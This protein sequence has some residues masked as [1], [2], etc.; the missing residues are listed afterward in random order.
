MEGKYFLKVH[1]AQGRNLVAVCDEEIL[2]KV[3]RDGDVVLEVSVSFYR[4]DVVDL[5]RA[6][7]AIRSAD[8]AVITGRRIVE[9]LSELG[10][11]DKEFA[12]RVGDQLHIQI[13]RE[14]YGFWEDSA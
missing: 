6:V 1:R 11:I 5:D 9:K 3:F 2:G 13:V 8:I 7:E 10:I 4:G 14:V 12:L